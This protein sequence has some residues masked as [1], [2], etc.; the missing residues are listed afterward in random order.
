L[1]NPCSE[2]VV[3]LTKLDAAEI[4]AAF[5]PAKAI[6]EPLPRQRVL[7]LIERMTGE[8]TSA[9]DVTPLLEVLGRMASC[10]WVEGQ[11]AVVVR[12]A[13]EGS[14]VDL[15]TYDGLSYARIGQ[16]LPV[17]VALAE[18]VQLVAARGGRIGVLELLFDEPGVELQL[19]ASEPPPDSVVNMPPPDEEA[20]LSRRSTT[21]LSAVKVPPEARPPEGEARPP[22][23]E[24]REVKVEE[25]EVT[26][27]GTYSIKPVGGTD[28]E[29]D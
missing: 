10:S 26:R 17:R 14:E 6:S 2:G 23:G 21:K 9:D 16:P 24:A 7:S 27:P 1:V 11:L 13:P 22:E 8:A 15:L 18:F 25:L 19:A 12:S 28:D 20:P 5:A 4:D 3:S 29:W